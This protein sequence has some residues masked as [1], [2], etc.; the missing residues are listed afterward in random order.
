M[1]RRR[2]NY[3]FLEL[4]KILLEWVVLASFFGTKQKKNGER[5]NY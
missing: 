3:H 4:K 5:G 2:M 1:M